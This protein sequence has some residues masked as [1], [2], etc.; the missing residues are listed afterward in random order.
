MSPTVLSAANTAPWKVKRVSVTS[1]PRIAYGLSRSQRLP[2]YSLSA[3]IFTPRTMLPKA[4]PHSTAGISEVQK[5]ACSQLRCQ[6]SSG[7]LARYSKA[8]PRT[9]RQTRMSSSGR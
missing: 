8:T 4:T 7:R 2:T 6:R 3:S 1:P 9:I 5:I